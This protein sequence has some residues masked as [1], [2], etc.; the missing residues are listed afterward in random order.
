MRGFGVSRSIKL[1]LLLL[2]LQVGLVA[3]V[4]LRGDASDPF[5]ANASLFAVDPSYMDA[6]VIEQQNKVLKFVRK[7]GAWVL[8][9]K[10]DFP[11]L[12]D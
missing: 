5:E 8:P 6:V 7:D 1:L 10:A 11:V 12:R 9:D 2:V 4:Q 3:W